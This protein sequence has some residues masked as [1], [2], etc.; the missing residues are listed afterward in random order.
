MSIIV[1][2]YLFEYQQNKNRESELERLKSIVTAE[3]SD[4]VS[5]L[6]GG[7]G[8]AITLP[9]GD[10]VNVLVTLISP[11]EKKLKNFINWLRISLLT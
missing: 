9:D 3:S 7:E 8:M 4:I 2:I 11:I 6:T 5:I 10:T 1:G